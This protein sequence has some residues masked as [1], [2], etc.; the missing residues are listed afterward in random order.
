MN[1]TSQTNERKPFMEPRKTSKK[2][3]TLFESPAW[4]KWTIHVYL[5]SE[6]SPAKQHKNSLLHYLQEPALGFRLQS[7][8]FFYEN[9]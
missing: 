6:N 4:L 8:S 1:P 7:N 9:T 3:M 5:F 2:F